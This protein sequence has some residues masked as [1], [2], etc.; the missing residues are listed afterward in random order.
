MR[1]TWFEGV[2]FKNIRARAD[3]LR[4]ELKGFDATHAVEK[5]VFEDVV[6]NGQPLAAAD[7]KTNA[8]VRDLTIRP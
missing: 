2:T 8:F 4:V 7:V 5:V 3:P 6:V 1:G